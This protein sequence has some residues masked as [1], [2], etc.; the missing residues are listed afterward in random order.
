MKK[1]FWLATSLMLLGLL[2]ATQT[3]LAQ[4]PPAGRATMPAIGKIYGKVFEAGSRT[5]VEY[6]TVTVLAL[7]K[8]SIVGGSL[9]RSN[10]DFAIDKLPFGMYRV[11]I[12]FIGY[13]TLEKQ[14]SITPQKYEQDLGNL[15]LEIDAAQLATVEITEERNTMALGID[16]R[17]YNV[18]KDLTS[19]GGT[20][21]DV[22]RNIPGLTVDADGGVKLRNASPTIFVDGRPTTLT[23]EQIPA[24]QIERIE[25]ITNPSAKY[26][27]STTGGILNVV[28]KKN[29]KP[30][31]NGAVNAGIG[32][33]TRYN[34][35][36]NINVKEGKVNVFTSYNLNVNRFD[37]EGFT[38]RE[39]FSSEQ[40]VSG[41][42]QD[43]VATSGRQFQ[44]V[45]FGADYQISNRNLLTVSQNFGGGNFDNNERQS[46]STFDG[47]RQSVSTGTQ[48]NEQ[49]NFWRNS[50]MQVIFRHN[51]PKAGKEWTTDLTYNRSR[52][53]TDALYSLNSLNPAGDTL[54][55]MPRLQKNDGGGQNQ[56]VT[57]QFDYV[58]PLTEKT[59]LEWGL[60]SNYRQNSSDLDVR[61]KQG[62]AD[63]LPDTSLTNY[64]VVD[65]IINAA[66]INMSSSYRKWNYQAGL[67]FEQTYFVADIT[68]K[69]QNFS[70]IYPDGLDN[71]GK[72]LFPSVF[73]SRKY[74]ENREFQANFSRKVNRPGFFQMMPFIM[75]ADAQSFRIGNPAL[76][77][78]FFNIAEINYS[79]I[80]KKG[81]YLGSLY[82]RQTQDVITNYVYVLPTDSSILVSS[83]INGNNQY[84][85]GTEHTVKYSPI[86]TFDL[87]LNANVFY[88]DIEG[89]DAIGNLNNQGFSWN[90]KLI[91][92]YRLPKAWT[93]QLNGE[94]EAPRIIPQGRTNHVYGADFSVNK[95][96]T[97][98]WTLNLS[99][100][101]IFNTRRFGAFYS[102]PFFTQEFI[103]RRDTRFLRFT[104]SYRFGEFD[105]SLLKR[106]RRPSGGG[107]GMD[108][109]F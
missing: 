103:R 68:N 89:G 87:T 81:N 96:L 36:G 85:Y 109:D 38:D 11:K 49:A 91:A 84:S 2:L 9:V 90:T 50:S 55:G 44:F 4:A 13:K 62:A 97:K 37:V 23:L 99:L 1:F 51:A 94:Y 27:A 108:M 80:F 93:L 100:V 26:D 101:D 46:F 82:F 19:Q 31:Y 53:G 24:E 15:R 74:G 60:R 63:F 39:N 67:R 29:T 22:M 52:N 64:F 33:N 32:T 18:D 105:A 104:V 77:P 106:M 73:L 59:K 69:G 65:D 30:G 43:N 12:S 17:T 95:A 88:T 98:S 45:R 66:Y 107:G 35:G 71:L 25:V 14:V 72:A 28:L 86:K 20:G 7:K 21:L 83:F 57:F 58:D 34:V 16:R 102:T 78:E 61:I 76:A 8:D 75:F 48:F 56:V 3:L 79:Q 42:R 54:P 6:A 47:N 5:A 10:G 70:Y 41:F 92:S 40:L